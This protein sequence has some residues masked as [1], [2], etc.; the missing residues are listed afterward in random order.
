MRELD[1]GLLL[2]WGQ[3]EVTQQGA[4][5]APRTTNGWGAVAT[6]LP[7]GPSRAEAEP[8]KGAG[9]GEGT[10]G[11]HDLGPTQGLASVSTSAQWG[12]PHDL[13]VG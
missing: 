3:A 11:L 9:E 2:R 1:R 6:P 10:W 8:R 13:R 5:G 7:P 12:Q 4:L